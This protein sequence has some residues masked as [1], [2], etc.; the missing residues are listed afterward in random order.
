LKK[1][2]I[3]SLHVPYTKQTHHM[4]NQKTINQMKDGVILINTARGKVVDTDA[5]YEAYLNGKFGG[6]GLDVFEDK[7]VLILK[8]YREGIASDKKLKILELANKD[9]VIVTTTSLITPIN[10]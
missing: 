6:L 3:V 1:S 8:K 10:L 7:E 2:D 9:N 4:L 5:L